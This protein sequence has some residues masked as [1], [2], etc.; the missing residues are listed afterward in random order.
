MTMTIVIFLDLERHKYSIDG[1]PFSHL[2]LSFQVETR[3]SVG[4]LAV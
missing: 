1:P 4:C 2:T 3:N